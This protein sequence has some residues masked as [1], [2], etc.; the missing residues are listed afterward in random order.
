MW[1]QNNTEHTAENSLPE[2]S[3]PELPTAGQSSWGNT[4]TPQGSRG[5]DRTT[6]DTEDNSLPEHPQPE[7]PTAGQSSRGNTGTS[8]NST[9]RKTG[10]WFTKPHFR[11]VGRGISK[12]VRCGF[13]SNK[14]MEMTY[15]IWIF[16]CYDTQDV[17]AKYGSKASTTDFWLLIII[18]SII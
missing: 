1:R 4:D 13:I 7:P 10:Y 12:F 9:V 8:Q 17:V 6:D 18:H 5:Q 14:N 11:H 15:K 2:Q 16:I 3:W